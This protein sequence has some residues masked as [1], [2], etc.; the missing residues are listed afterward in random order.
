MTS[1]TT[2]QPPF[3]SAFDPTERAE[4]NADPLSLQRYYERLAE[5]IYPHI[6]VRMRRIRFLT[7]TAVAAHVCQDLGEVA[8]DGV[9]PPW[10]AFEWNMLEALGLNGRF[11]VRGDTGGYPG[12]QKVAA[13]INRREP[14]S[15]SNYLKAPQ[16]FGY[17]GVHK[18][19]ANGLGVVNDSMELEGAGERLLRAWEED[20]GLVGFFTSTSSSS[21]GNSLR[22]SLR[23]SIEQTLSIA[24]TSMNGSRSTW[25]Q[26]APRLDPDTIGRRERGVLTD[27]LFSSVPIRKSNDDDA[28]RLRSQLLEALA[29]R[30]GLKGYESDFL[31]AAARGIDQELRS[32]LSNIEAFERVA[33]L[34]DEAFRLQIRL[35][36]DDP[37]YVVTRVTFSRHGDAN[38]VANNLGSVLDAMYEQLSST[39]HWS[40]PASAG[41]S[42]I[43]PLHAA[44]ADVRNAGEL[45]DALLTY[46]EE[47]QRL[48]PPDGRRPWFGRTPG[49][50]DRAFLRPSLADAA[51][52]VDRGAYVHDYRSGTA[53]RFLKDLGR[54]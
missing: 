50:D 44:F 43:G 3:V 24:Q 29:Q 48:K 18:R 8:S 6:T 7:A 49:S 21:S 35:A 26:F 2:L 52:G 20:E 27:L 47:V 12:S 39:V 42:G 40:V 28:F 33:K 46:H 34:L 41:D 9:T 31:K 30:R 4:S 54:I 19:L 1:H 17:T 25:K 10:L 14:V 11:D 53:Q 13:A 38:R 37:S 45:F 16:V 22:R 51:N 23:A 36:A 32:R 5:C 15:A